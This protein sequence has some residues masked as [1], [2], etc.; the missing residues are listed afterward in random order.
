MAKTF[1]KTDVSKK[2]NHHNEQNK[3]GERLGK[4][5]ANSSGRIKPLSCRSHA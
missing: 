4:N 5:T 3:D 1:A 2:K